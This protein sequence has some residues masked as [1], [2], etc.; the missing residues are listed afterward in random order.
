MMMM[1]KNTKRATKSQRGI[2]KEENESGGCAILFLFWDEHERRA[3]EL[4]EFSGDHV[5]RKNRERKEKKRQK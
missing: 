2:E 4:G 3:E 1:P 5:L